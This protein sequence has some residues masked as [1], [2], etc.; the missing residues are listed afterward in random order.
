MS[1]QHHQKFSVLLSNIFFL[2]IIVMKKYAYAYIM[3]IMFA[4]YGLYATD[5][6]NISRRIY[7]III[8]MSALF[9]TLFAVEILPILFKNRLYRK[10]TSVEFCILFL[11]CYE[12][13]DGKKK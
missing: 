4:F 8:V 9:I 13:T 11:G 2:I 7:D 12:A 10:I 6:V 1:D 3:L 5:F